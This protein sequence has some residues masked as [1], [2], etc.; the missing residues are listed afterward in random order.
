MVMCPS[1]FA[2]SSLFSTA[3]GRML[4]TQ[5]G[6][7]R[8][9]EPTGKVSKYRMRNGKG[10]RHGCIALDDSLH[11]ETHLAQVQHEASRMP[12][13]LFFFHRGSILRTN[14]H[15]MADTPKANN[16]CPSACG[17]GRERMRSAAWRC[18]ILKGLVHCRSKL[19]QR[20]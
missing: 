18:C 12:G 15:C 16:A 19:S 9:A 14:G 2:C 11:G 7:K 3:Y 1:L 6:R 20:Y 5:Y 4:S 8:H 17:C 13:C 10:Q